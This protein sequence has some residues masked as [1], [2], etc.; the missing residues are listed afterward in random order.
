[1]ANNRVNRNAYI[2]YSSADGPFEIVEIEN[3]EN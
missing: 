2:T 3:N 1:M